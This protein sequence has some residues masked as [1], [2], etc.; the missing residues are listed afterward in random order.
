[1]SGTRHRPQWTCFLSLCQDGAIAAD[2]NGATL[3]KQGQNAKSVSLPNIGSTSRAIRFQSMPCDRK[4]D[5]THSAAALAWSWVESQNFVDHDSWSSNTTSSGGICQSA[6]HGDDSKTKSVDRGGSA[7]HAKANEL[8]D[9][10]ITLCVDRL[11]RECKQVP[12]VCTFDVSPL[13]S[14]VGL[15]LLSFRLAL[16]MICKTLSHKT[17]N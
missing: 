5:A 2:A 7:S 16:C 12:T 17:S 10:D 9:D 3:A 15:L 4:H 13:K 8:Q 1:M 11:L 14:S 6:L